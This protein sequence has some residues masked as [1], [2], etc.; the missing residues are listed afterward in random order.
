MK[1]VKVNVNERVF[2]VISFC[3]KNEKN[4][5]AFEHDEVQFKQEVDIS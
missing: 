5:V 2:I 3:G 4:T 1:S